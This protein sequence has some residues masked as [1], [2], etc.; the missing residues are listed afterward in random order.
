MLLFIL[1]IILIV[2]GIVLVIIDYK[3][4]YDVGVMTVIGAALSLIATVCIIVSLFHVIPLHSHK[5]F[6]YQLMLDRKTAFEYRLS[7]IDENPNGNER[8]L[9]EIQSFNEEIA[10]TKYYSENPW[11]NWFYNEKIG[12]IETIDIKE[13]IN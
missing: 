13:Y 2:I 8:L 9:S 7:H 3:Y 6:D 10:T 5:D 4:N 1:F 12:S 11:V